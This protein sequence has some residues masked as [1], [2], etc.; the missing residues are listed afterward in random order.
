MFCFF[1]ARSLK[2]GISFLTKLRTAIVT[3]P[4]CFTCGINYVIIIICFLASLPVA[5]ALTFENYS[6]FTILLTTSLFTT[7]LSLL[8]STGEV[9][10][11]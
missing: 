9:S 11:S 7:L 5:I 4:R 6:S 8:K 3:K 2:L 1:L 10:N